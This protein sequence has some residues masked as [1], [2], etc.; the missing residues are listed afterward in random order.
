MSLFDYGQPWDDGAAY[1]EVDHHIACYVSDTYRG[2]KELHQIPYTLWQIKFG[3]QPISLMDARSWPGHKTQSFYFQDDIWL[4]S[5]CFARDTSGFTHDYVDKFDFN[6][7]HVKPPAQNKDKY[8]QMAQNAKD[9]N[10]NIR[11]VIVCGNIR[12]DGNAFAYMPMKIDAISN[13]G[14]DVSVPRVEQ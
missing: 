14:I 10:C 12:T 2:W 13:D 6:K 5:V 3:A 4:G 9:K 1:R 7:A 11:L 8:L